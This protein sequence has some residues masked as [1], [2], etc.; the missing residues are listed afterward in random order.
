MLDHPSGHRETASCLSASGFLEK[1]IVMGPKPATT[2]SDAQLKRLLSRKDEPSAPELEEVFESVMAKVSAPEARSRIP[3]FGRRFLLAAVPML[4]LL[5]GAPVA[6]SL[7]TR[8]SSRFVS[9]GSGE[10]LSDFAATCLG[11]GPGEC[12]L[13][14]K[15]TFRL[16]SNAG[17]AFLAV[18][19]QGPAGTVWYFP[20]GDRG[21]SVEIRDVPPGGVMPQGV[22]VGPEHV[23]GEYEVF[24][25]FSS[26]PL[27]RDAVRSAIDGELGRAGPLVVKRR[28]T[29]RAP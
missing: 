7:L 2:L 26:S 11:D 12:T 1:E 6:Y 14:H 3:I 24:G 15:M 29:V 28:L 22:L 19:A 23:P 27:N 10:A 25:V 21:T 13:G 8:P 16:S 5:V 9:R 18:V 17:W 20:G 4:L